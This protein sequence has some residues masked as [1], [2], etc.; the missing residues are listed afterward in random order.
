MGI[1]PIFLLAILALAAGVLGGDAGIAAD[2]SENRQTRTEPRGSKPAEPRLSSAELGALMMARIGRHFV[3]DSRHA[4]DEGLPLIFYD[5]PRP[6]GLWLCRVNVFMVPDQIVRGDEEANG[7]DEL[8]LYTKYA[9]WRRPTAPEPSAQEREAG[10]AAY[11]D[12]KHMFGSPN[13]GPE[14]R[15]PYVADVIFEQ[16]SSGHATIPLT[17]EDHRPHSLTGTCNALDVLRGLTLKDLGGVET[18]SEKEGDGVTTY[19]DQLTFDLKHNSQCCSEELLRMTVT[20][21]QHWAR[22]GGDRADPRSAALEIICLC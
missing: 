6:F 20:S 9:I 22:Q 18:K 8:E 10:C 14:E 2:R 16:I 13:P 19:E 21:D 3:A 11:R 7:E 12:F 15:G 4:G 1:K 5:R 17:C